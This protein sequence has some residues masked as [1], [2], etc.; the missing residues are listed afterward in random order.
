[1]TAGR[2]A[3]RA[4]ARA[5]AVADIL[6][7][8]ATF[9][10][11][12]NWF[13]TLIEAGIDIN[14]IPKEQ[15]P[16]VWLH[17]FQAIQ[18]RNFRAALAGRWPTDVGHGPSKE[19][20]NVNAALSEWLRSGPQSIEVSLITQY[21][22]TKI[23]TLLWLREATTELIERLQSQRKGSRTESVNTRLLRELYD[24]YVDITGKEGLWDTGPAHRFC[25][26]S[27]CENVPA[28]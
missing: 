14:G 19:L 11:D 22:H 8:K 25:K 9:M 20:L 4:A 17:R 16:V 3:A 18:L 28:S 24:L 13:E 2:A 7:G 27:R 6:A 23:E 5:R 15:S 1:M 21:D 12:L 10:G 26:S